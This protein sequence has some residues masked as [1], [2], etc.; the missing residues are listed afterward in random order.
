M[1]IDGPG[2]FSNDYGYTTLVMLR[3]AGGVEVERIIADASDEY[4][5]EGSVVGLWL[6]AE[7]SASALGAHGTHRA[8]DPANSE[9][10]A[11][12]ETSRNMPITAGAVQ[13]VLNLLDYISQHENEYLEAMEAHDCV[14]EWRT[15]LYE[16][17][18]RLAAAAGLLARD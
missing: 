9:H 15:A 7:L 10:A 11:F 16:L 14:E 4:P 2:L 17:R 6:L 1:A 8:I 12:M 5:V 13:R 18:F 3:D